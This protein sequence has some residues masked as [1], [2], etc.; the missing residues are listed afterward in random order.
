MNTN[1]HTATLAGGYFWYLEAVFNEVR[2]VHG[3]E[4]G[5]AASG[6]DLGEL[7][8]RQLE[9]KGQ[10]R[11]DRCPRA[12]CMICASRLKIVDKS[13]AKTSWRFNRVSSARASWRF[14]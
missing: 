12:A 9:L 8:Q 10:E 6:L 13:T 4:S 11:T 3:V 2:G 1:L 14:R 5:Y 7:E